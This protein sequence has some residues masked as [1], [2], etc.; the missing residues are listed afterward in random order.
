MRNGVTIMTFEQSFSLEETDKLVLLAE[1]RADYDTFES[2]HLNP[3]R[4]PR[5]A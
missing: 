5:T 1:K 3:N 2:T 4:Q